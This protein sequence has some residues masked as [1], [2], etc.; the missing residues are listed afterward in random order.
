MV[1]LLK[2]GFLEVTKDRNLWLRKTWFVGLWFLDLGIPKTK[3]GK[4]ELVY[5][6]K[7]KL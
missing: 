1:G 2:L 5:F 6:D 7:Q 4:K 3:P